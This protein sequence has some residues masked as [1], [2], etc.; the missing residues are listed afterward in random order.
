MTLVEYIHESYPIKERLEELNNDPIKRV[1]ES[2]GL[3]FD[4]IQVID[5]VLQKAVE[6]S[7][8]TYVAVVDLLSYTKEDIDGL[9]PED[10]DFKQAYYA[11]MDNVDLTDMTI[12]AIMSAARDYAENKKREEELYKK[13][14]G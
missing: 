2:D 12:D 9:G 3:P 11:Y 14:T 4:S 1:M 13:C 8:D 6:I 10:N 5:G 7:Q